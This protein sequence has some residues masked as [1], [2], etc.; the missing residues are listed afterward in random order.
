[1]NATAGERFAGG[2]LNR[3]SHA[4]PQEKVVSGQVPPL[5]LDAQPVRRPSKEETV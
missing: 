5:E 1:M 2:G 4:Q 3:H